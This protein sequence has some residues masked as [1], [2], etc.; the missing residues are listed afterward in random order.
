MTREEKFLLSNSL[1]KKKMFDQD[2][3]KIYKLILFLFENR[4]INGKIFFFKYDSLNKLKKN[5]KK[6]IKKNDLYTIRRIVD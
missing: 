2:Y 3:L 6:I 4:F 5:K 1:K